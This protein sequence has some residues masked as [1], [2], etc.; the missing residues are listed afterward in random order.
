[1]HYKK[2][3]F[4]TNLVF[5]VFVLKTKNEKVQRVVKIQSPCTIIVWFEYRKLN[6][7]FCT[8]LRRHVTILKIAYIK[9][10]YFLSDHGYTH[11]S[12]VK[13]SKIERKML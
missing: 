2:I 8:N 10:S 6:Q 7:I 1:M 11:K 5:S 13:K 3:D 4:I 12:S 9:C